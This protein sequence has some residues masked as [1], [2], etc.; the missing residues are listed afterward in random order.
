[1][2]S[3]AELI[4]DFVI[5]ALEHIEAIEPLLLDIE[6]GEEP[7]I[8]TW[9][10][11]FRA[12]HSIKG[13]A[14]FLGF[15]NIQDISHVS[16]SM[17]MR[18]R[19]G[20]LAFDASMVSPLLEVLDHLRTMLGELPDVSTFAPGELIAAIN[21]LLNGD[22]PAGEEGR[23]ALPNPA[24][25][26]EGM[27]YLLIE[28]KKGWEREA[29]LS[30]CAEVGTL[31]KIPGPDERG[32][33][34]VSGLEPKVLAERVGIPRSSIHIFDPSLH[35]DVR[36]GEGESAPTV[37]F[38][39]LAVEL[40]FLSPQDIE[41]LVAVQESQREKVSLGHLAVDLGRMTEEQVELTRYEQLLRIDHQEQNESARVTAPQGARSGR[42]DS[43]TKPSSDSTKGG[44]RSGRKARNETIRVN[45]SLL[46]TLINLAGELVLGRNQLRQML[47]SVDIPGLKQILQSVDLVTTELQE[48][49]LYTRMQPVRVLFD[50]LPRQIR[51]AATKLSK[52]VD[53]EVSGTE[54]EL[55]RSL[56]EALADPMTHLIRNAIDHGIE[57]PAERVAAGKDSRGSLSV[58]AFHESGQVL[59]EIQDDGKGIDPQRLRQVAVDR[60]LHTPDQAAGLSDKEAI[61]LIFHAGL[62]TAKQV[63]D[64]S[65][66]GVGMDV[67]RSNIKAL[68]GQVEVESEVGVGT[69]F[70]VR[71]PLTLAIIP[72]LTISVAGQ[73]FAIP[74]VNLVEVVRLREGEELSGLE[75]VR[76]T[77]VMRLRGQLLPLVRLDACLGI[78][79]DEPPSKSNV[80]VL[81]S[82]N[83]QYGL[84]VDELHDSEEIVVKPLAGLLSSCYWYAGSTILGDGQVVMILEAQGLAKH[85]GLELTEMRELLGESALNAHHE[86][87]QAPSMIIFTNASGEYFA[88]PQAQIRRLEKIRLEDIETVGQR[89]FIRHRDRSIPLLRLETVLPIQPADVDGGEAFVLIPRSEEFEVG[90]FA[91]RIVDTLV[92]DVEPEPHLISG[93]GLLGSAILDDRLTLFL[94]TNQLLEAFHLEPSR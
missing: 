68:G 31:L 79:R 84:I 74:Q 57:T 53:L 12:L 54:V 35:A 30:A 78:E 5:E 66:R 42:S 85:A 75:V 19:D 27:R 88:L 18:L 82:G 44:G 38:G 60:G 47:E 76:G 65:G 83:G 29:V 93:P 59:I 24:P 87:G 22:A 37:L 20:E 34:L 23:K 58:R 39:E 69:T 77:E 33:H 46:N 43:S 91:T 45:V 51:D 61:N 6:K 86:K 71:L 50:R 56:I 4:D 17:L 1:M 15:D 48:N 13:A 9:N 40:G 32:I 80:V 52:E 81:R 14:G 25:E 16:E 28:P 3:D 89:E 92:S 10:S 7:E 94:D 26:P 11:I 67:V 36:Y 41:E 8:E 55:D 63:T 21:A 2:E 73:R 49:I 70:R 64:I 90:I 62:S 72:S